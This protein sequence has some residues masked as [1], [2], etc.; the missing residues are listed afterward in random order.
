MYGMVNQAVEG[1]ISERFGADVWRQVKARA[2]VRE[3][4]FLQMKP[5]PDAI[6]YQLVGAA[7]DILDIPAPAL[8]EA[9]GEYWT[10]YTG[11]H[12]YG[13]LFQRGGRTFL[14]FMVNLHDLHSHVGA[15]FP[16]LRP[17]SFW[18]S[19]VGHGRLRLHYQSERE[20]LAP[21]VIGLVKGLGAMYAT[22][23]TVTHV[24]FRS[25]SGH[26]EFEVTFAPAGVVGA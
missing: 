2:G 12:G 23:V 9:F 25:A 3:E 20:G 17:P 21:M 4:V 5:Y 24:V 10:L 8:L 1:L 13:E 14:E 22:T 11:R 16:A 26:D 6:T 18:C 7:S 15:S 19:D